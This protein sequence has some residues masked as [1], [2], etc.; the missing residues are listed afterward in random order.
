M[1]AAAVLTTLALMMGV[2]TMAPTQGAPADDA[3]VS[4]PSSPAIPPPARPTSIFEVHPAN[5]ARVCPRP[6]IGTRLRLTDRTR[7]D[8]A[9][10]VSTIT[11]RLDGVDVT[12]RARTV[13]PAI[14]P[15]AQASILYL[16]T[17]PLSVGRHEA[18]VT[19]PEASGRQTFRWVFHVVQVPC[20]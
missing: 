10:D 3:A 14:Y 5:G 6:Q 13:V 8:G 11:L 2:V 4:S 19:V 20:P 1:R 17:R 9:F 7:R 15:H 16:P 12:G 18:A